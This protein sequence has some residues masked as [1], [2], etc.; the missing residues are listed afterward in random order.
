MDDRLARRGLLPGPDGVW[1]LPVLHHHVEYADLVRRVIDDLAPDAVAVELPDTL[2]APLLGAVERLPQVS[3]LVY[4]DDEGRSVYLP[5]EVADPLVEALRRARETGARPACV[6]VDVDYPLRHAEA[7]PDTYALLSIGPRAY[8]EAYLA[9]TASGGAAAA[10]DLDRVRE[11]GMA[12]RIQRLRREHDTVLAVCGMAHARRLAADLERHQA[13]PM[14]R[15]RRDA[16]AVFNVHPDSLAEVLLTFPLLSAVAERRRHGRPAEPTEEAMAPPRRKASAAEFLAVIDGERRRHEDPG[17]PDADLDASLDWIARRGH[18]L[19]EACGAG[20]W[21]AGGH[22]PLDRRRAHDALLRRAARRYERRTGE[23]VQPWQMHVLRRFARNYALLEGRLLP[24]LYQLFIAARGSVDDNYG[25][26]VWELG[27]H[28]PWQR[29]DAELPTVRLTADQLQ[30][31]TRTIRLR[32]RDPVAKRRLVPLDRRKR[33]RFRGEW[34]EGFDD[35]GLCSYPPEDVVIEDYGRYLRK[36]GVQIVSDDQARV[37]PFSSSLKDGIDVRETLRNWHEGT[38]YV[39]EERLVRGGVGSVVIVFDEDGDDRRYPFR[40]TWHG[41]HEQESD[42]AFYSTDLL[43][44]IVG[45]G[46]SRCEYGG[47]LLSYPPLRMM[48]VWSDPDYRGARSKAEV[49]MMAGIDY[50]LDTHVVVVAARPPRSAIRRYAERH[51]R[52]VVYLPIGQLSPASLKRIR[53]FHILFG[54]D[55]RDTAPEFIW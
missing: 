13:A 32:R 52:K 8:L 39:R 31:G 50:S 24:D 14:A 26:E 48:D 44:Q 37:E 30:L 22:L 41:E 19:D 21:E 27:V 3:V 34:I 2:E 9:A 11:R 47:L 55:K 12:F 4:Q 35:G 16:V 49:L 54:K 40:M 29:E 6:D 17:G 23:V 1:I 45:P 33:R 10:T 38:I 5:V 43:G 46:I 51:Q 18:T 20:A 15:T 7:F 28:Y 36:K 53:V 42:M 25:Y